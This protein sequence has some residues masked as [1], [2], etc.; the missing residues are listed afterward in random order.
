M[1]HS[2]ALPPAY[3]LPGA[4]CPDDLPAYSFPSGAGRVVPRAALNLTEV[5]SDGESS[6]EF[7]YDISLKGKKSCASLVVHGDPVLSK[8]LPTFVE[9]S[10]LNGAVKLS[11][12]SG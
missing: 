2:T 3:D 6:K 7:K 4:D 9:G 12:E 1:Q 8:Q 11:L 10:N 5:S